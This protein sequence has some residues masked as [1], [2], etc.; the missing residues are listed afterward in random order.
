M[1][2]A[3]EEAI[4]IVGSQQK[5]AC[6]VGIQQSTVSKWLRGSEIK[7]RYLKKIELATNGKV[8]IS[9]ILKSLSNF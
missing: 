1:N 5:L 7:S 9:D 3:I 8:S 4:S 2:K 6:M